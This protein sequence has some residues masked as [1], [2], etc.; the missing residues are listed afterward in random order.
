MVSLEE[1]SRLVME[2]GK[3]AVMALS[4]KLRL[5]VIRELLSRSRDL[6][7]LAH[8]IHVAEKEELRRRFME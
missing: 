3:L 7:E 2:Y 5:T 6:D 1:S 4:S 8:L